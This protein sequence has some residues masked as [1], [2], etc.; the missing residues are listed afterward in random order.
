MLLGPFARQGAWARR[1]PLADR[2]ALV[3]R[4]DCS[5][6]ARSL[7]TSQARTTRLQRDP[8]RLRRSS[9]LEPWSTRR[10]SL[11]TLRRAIPRSAARRRCQP[12]TPR[13]TTRERHGQSLE[14]AF[15]DRKRLFLKVNGPPPA[16]YVAGEA[17]PLGLNQRPLRIRRD[18]RPI[19]AADE[20]RFVLIRRALSHELGR[21]ACSA[22]ARTG[23]ER[24]GSPSVATSRRR[25]RCSG[26][27]RP[28]TCGCR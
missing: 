26:L 3:V 27:C 5:R 8:S 21:E 23:R 20:Q 13:T 16:G 7:T 17:S 14:A 11:P 25:Q 15:D 24:G 28:P 2:S 10:P 9:R 22:G 4:S 1:V 19:P 18:Q 6:Y 12:R